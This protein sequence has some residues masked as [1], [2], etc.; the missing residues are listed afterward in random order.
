[1]SEP[2]GPGSH[3]VL[4]T[5][6][7]VRR[8]ALATVPLWLGMAPFGLVLGVLADARGLSFA[9]TV[10]MSAVVYA[11]IAQLVALESWADPAPIVAAMVSAFVVNVRMAP[12]GAALA[13]WLDRL[14]GI[15]LWGT[16]ATLVDHSFALSVQE[17]RRGGRDAGYLLGVGL[18]L[19]VSWVVASA[20]G[21]VVAGLVRVPPGHPLFFASVAAFISILVGLWRSPREDLAP[22]AVA[23]LLAYAAH[24]AALP[25]PLPLLIGSLGGAALG[26]FI[27]LR[28]R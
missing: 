19:W 1:V 27:E 20:V 23:G 18:A 15:R 6:D 12:Q 13:G 8:G 2:A 5:R 24:R 3:R 4:F 28:R 14:K 26:A 9:E 7:G 16:L 25:V 22:W 21:Y 17:Q 10:L 11:G